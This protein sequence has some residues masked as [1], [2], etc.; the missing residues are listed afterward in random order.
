MTETVKKKRS[1]ILPIALV[2]VT[3]AVWIIVM[4][5]V[6]AQA[7]YRERAQTPVPA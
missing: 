4:T 5:V 3:I 6:L 2:V 1:L 7:I